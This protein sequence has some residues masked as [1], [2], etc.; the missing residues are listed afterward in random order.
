MGF[1]FRVEGLGVLGFGFW[2]WGSGFWFL[3]VGFRVRSA[4]QASI[5]KGAD[6]YWVKEYFS[7]LRRVG[8]RVFLTTDV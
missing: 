2:V 3:V 7:S 1:G 6:E 5:H 4:K 8:F